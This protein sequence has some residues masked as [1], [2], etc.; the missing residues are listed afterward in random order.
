MT[1]VKA[2]T[3]EKWF[4]D[5]YVI[6]LEEEENEDMKQKKKSLEVQSEQIFCKQTDKELKTA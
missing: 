5:K 2:G 1:V 4:D 3:E 6:L